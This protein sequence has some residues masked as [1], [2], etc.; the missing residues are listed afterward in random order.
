ML[1]PALLPEL[2]AQGS[3]ARY[4]HSALPHAETRPHVEPKR[5]VRRLVT[6]M[7][8]NRQGSNEPVAIELAPA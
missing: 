3:L 6:A 2:Y 8:R 5:R 1:P 7:R 4:G